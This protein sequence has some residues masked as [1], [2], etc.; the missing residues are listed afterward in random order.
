[1]I[2]YRRIAGLSQD[3]EKDTE[4]WTWPVMPRCAALR[5][6]PLWC[7]CGGV[8]AAVR[9]GELAASL[10]TTAERQGADAVADACALS[11]AAAARRVPPC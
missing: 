5:D 11:A 2:H 8:Q 10:V 3:R 7:C 4:F 1:M 9:A 6:P